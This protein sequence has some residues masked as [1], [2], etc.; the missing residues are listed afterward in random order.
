MDEARLEIGHETM[1]HYNSAITCFRHITIDHDV[2]ISWNANI[3]DGNIHELIVGGVPRP[4]HKA[5]NIGRHAWIGTG[6]TIIGAAIGE[7]SVVG[8]G[9]VVVS[10]V[11]SR[12]VV[13]GNPARVVA[14]DVSWKA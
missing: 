8:A 1:I 10:D 13:A 4:R 3:L 2:A 5:V 11:P 9:S 7:G 12:V 6:A 14:K